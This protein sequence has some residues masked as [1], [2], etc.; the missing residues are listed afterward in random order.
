[1]LQRVYDWILAHAQKPY[2]VWLMAAIS[3]TESSFFP[4]PPD[5]LLIPMVLA[6]R[7][8]AFWLATVATV[9]SVIGGFLGYAI[10][11]Y[12]FDTIGSFIVDHVVGAQVFDSLKAQFDEYG[13]WA[14]IVKGATPIPYKI[15]TILSGF[16]HFDLAQFTIASIIA[17]GMRFY[18][19]A[20]LLYYFGAA[21]KDFIEKRLLLVTTAVAG[22]LVGGFVL[23]KV[24]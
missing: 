21:A 8:R 3:F 18:A 2:A 17:R 4:A 7:R 23:L 20:V 10:G 6:D 1:M 5:I 12:A 22:L 9:S 16:L 13:F 15:V 14:I 11:Y 19:E 24:L